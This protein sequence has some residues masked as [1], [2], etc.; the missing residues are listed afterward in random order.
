MSIFSDSYISDTVCRTPLAT[1]GY[2]RE[3]LQYAIWINIK[4]LVKYMGLEWITFDKVIARVT[5][6]IIFSFILFQSYKYM[7]ADIFHTNGEEQAQLFCW[8]RPSLLGDRY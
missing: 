3:I 5:I 4:K 1:K 7:H 8:Y 6:F 2:F